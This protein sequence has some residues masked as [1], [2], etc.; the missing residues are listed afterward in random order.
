[1]SDFE[2]KQQERIEELFSDFCDG[3]TT[4]VDVEY[5]IQD[6]TD[7]SSFNEVSN[8]IEESNA[9]DGE[10]IYYSRAMEFLSDNDN[11]LN[12]SL[13]I[14]AEMGYET[15]NL[16]SEL[17][18]TLLNSQMIREEW[19]ET[20]DEWDTLFEEIEEIQDEEEPEE[21]EEE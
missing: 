15:E 7:Y 2:E 5:H 3:L 20:E 9:F 6:I 12:K 11:S 13:S 14:A 8:A 16:N 19:D 4:E 1:M 18:A 21:E 17:L 10:I